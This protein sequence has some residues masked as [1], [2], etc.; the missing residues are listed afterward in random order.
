MSQPEA[1]SN[2]PGSWEAWFGAPP[3]P[4]CRLR[5]GFI[6]AAAVLGFAIIAFRLFGLQVNP[7]LR[8]SEEYRHHNAEIAIHQPRGNILD[9]NGRLLATDRQMPTLYA[10]PSRVK[11]PEALAQ[12]LSVLLGVNEDLIYSR[13]NR[14]TPSGQLMQGV[15]VK[16]WLDNDEVEAL[17]DL[18]AWAGQSLWLR[19]E[20][21]RYYP[22]QQ[23]GAHLVGFVN[24]ESKGSEGVEMA[25][26]SVL[27]GVPGRVVSRAD[28]NRTLL[29]SLTLEER[30]PEGGHHVHM[31]MDMRIQHILE[32]ELDKAREET[33]AVRAMG[34]VMD[35][36]TGAI[37][38]MASRPAYDPNRFS[39]YPLEMMKNPA[40][41]DVFEPGSV[42]KIVTAAAALEHG[43]VTPEQPVDCQQGVMQQ[44]RR[45]I[46]D[47]YSLGVVPFYEAYAQSSNIAMINLAQELG[48]EL[49]EAW[50]RRFG[51]GQRTTP[52]FSGES[53]GIFRPRSQW[54]GYSMGS[55]PMGQEIAVTIPQLARAFAVIANG[56][57][58]VEPYLVE[59][60]V[61]PDGSLSYEREPAPP[62]QVLSAHTAETMRVLSH[63]VVSEG[64]GRRANIE[65]FR[66]GGKTGTAQMARTDGPGYDPDR[67]TAIFAGFAPISDPRLVSVIVVQEPQIRERWGG[68]I[69]GPIFKEVMRESL[70]M[71]NTPE[72]PVL[73]RATDE[74]QNGLN[75][76]KESGDGSNG[77]RDA[78]LQLL[79]L[80]ADLMQVGPRVP[81][82][83]GMTKRQAR[84]AVAHT[85]VEWDMQGAGWVIEQDP[86]PGTP[87]NE[88]TVCRLI[89]GNKAGGDETERDTE[90]SRLYD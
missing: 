89:F 82:L 6:A 78:D 69:C 62:Q 45:T 14:R 55:L 27:R 22:H 41:I 67:Y 49:M 51:F 4:R 25:F 61:A 56:G 40:I 21:I 23:L 13:L 46:R 54:S 30:A 70:I 33:G 18:R 88:V 16:R 58:L 34:M 1:P 36:H 2:E 28:A 11:E 32:Q 3:G 42:F 84:A 12:R 17:G 72:D 60:A 20:P 65:E 19:N 38:A 44:G 63:V 43:I 86:P 9:V 37:K 90:L 26:D 48:P 35:P 31:T 57:Y 24:R 80:E 71:M 85:G 5:M 50:I 68:F 59:R 81:D 74:L 79:A 66:A 87:L 77:D 10:N 7:D 29:A 52:D 8:L 76:E 15:V 73:A 47:F 53:P 64:T 39:Q 75:A 83:M